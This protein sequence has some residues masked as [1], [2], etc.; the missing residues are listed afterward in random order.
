MGDKTLHF[1]SN[2]RHLTQKGRSP[3]MTALFSIILLILGLVFP[4]TASGHAAR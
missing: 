4:L 2:G 3:I 1:C